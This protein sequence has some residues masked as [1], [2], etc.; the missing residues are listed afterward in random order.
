[1]KLSEIVNLAQGLRV[2]SNERPKGSVSYAAAVNMKRT[3]PFVQSFDEA[4]KEILER[5]C[6]R[7]ENGSLKIEN[8]QYILTD[9]EAAFAEVAE[10]GNR[11][12]EISLSKI[13]PDQIF[14]MNISPEVVAAIMPMIEE[15]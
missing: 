11:E 4:R 1:M 3:S 8:G 14:D 15:G 9:P 6:E 10:L 12:E 5:H 2:F 7:N 13:K